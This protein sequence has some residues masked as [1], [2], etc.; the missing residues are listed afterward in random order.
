MF[1]Q[2]YP[3]DFQQLETL[4]EQ[5][6]IDVSLFL[7][8]TIFRLRPYAVD[9][10]ITLAV[11]LRRADDEVIQT[12][13]LKL[14]WHPTSDT[15]VIPPVQQHTITEWVACGIALAIVQI[16]L[17]YQVLE[18]AQISDRFDYWLG[19]TVREV[20]LEISG[21]VHGNLATRTS[22]KEQQ[23]KRNPYKSAGYVCVVG[24]ERRQVQLSFYQDEA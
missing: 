12:H 2:D 22:V 24:F 1:K 13:E 3:R 21:T 6:A 23:L 4:M 17:P 9:R 19:E 16:Y 10:Q 20:G 14:T 5:A 11:S 8:F 7:P 15:L 18:V